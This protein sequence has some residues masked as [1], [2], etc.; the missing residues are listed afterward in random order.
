MSSISSHY[1][2]ITSVLRQRFPIHLKFH[3]LPPSELNRKLLLLHILNYRIANTPLILQF[4]MNVA[5]MLVD[6]KFH[7]W[8]KKHERT[9]LWIYHQHIIKTYTV[10]AT[11]TNIAVHCYKKDFLS[12]GQ[13]LS[14]STCEPVIIIMGNIYNMTKIGAHRNYIESFERPP[15]SYCFF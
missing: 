11:L 5:K 12:A 4:W 7:N 9:F 2:F 10:V 14:P 13:L 1:P 6:P 8:H 3:R 15:T